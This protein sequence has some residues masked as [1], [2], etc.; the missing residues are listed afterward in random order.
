MTIRNALYSISIAMEDENE[1]RASGII[2]LRDGQIVGGDSFFYYTG[3]Y[4]ADN[5][6]WKGELITHQHTDTPGK[7]PLFGGREVSCGFS[8]TYAD[9]T[10]E[11]HGT[12]LVGK[13]SIAFR[14]TMRLLVPFSPGP[15]EAGPG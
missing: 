11:V 15:V 13:A 3:I 1:R 12:A 7:S 8:G 4:T 14:A 2:G 9:G 5:G 6:K 10:A